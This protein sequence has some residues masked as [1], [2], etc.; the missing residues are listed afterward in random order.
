MDGYQKSED[1][2]VNAYLAKQVFCWEGRVKYPVRNYI[3][4]QD[5]LTNILKGMLYWKSCILLQD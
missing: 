4:K 1:Q 3:Q 2:M 5:I